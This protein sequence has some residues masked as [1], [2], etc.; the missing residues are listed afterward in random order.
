MPDAQ[1][2][3]LRANHSDQRQQPG[4]GQHGL[5]LRP[6]TRQ[7][8]GKVWKIRRGPKPGPRSGGGFARAWQ[9]VM[10]GDYRKLHQLVRGVSAKLTDDRPLFEDIARVAGAAAIRRRATRAASAPASGA[11]RSMSLLPNV[12]LPPPRHFNS[13]QAVPTTVARQFRKR[14]GRPHA[15]RLFRQLVLRAV[16]PRAGAARRLCVA[17]VCAP[18]ISPSPARVRTVLPWIFSCACWG[19][20]RVGDG[21]CWCIATFFPLASRCWTGWPSSWAGAR[22]NAPLRARNVSRNFSTRA[23]ASS[24]SART[25]A[26]GKWPDTCWAASASR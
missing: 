3:G 22:M 23:K 16:D 7:L 21:R 8:T 10:G 15:R 14:A 19:R 4:R 2:P 5:H 25:S 24:C 11:R 17:G 13:P 9:N 20:S 1:R 26:A 12:W 6:L 18:R